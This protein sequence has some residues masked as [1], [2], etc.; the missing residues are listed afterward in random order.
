MYENRHLHEEYSLH[1]TPLV[2]HFISNILLELW[3]IGKKITVY[4]YIRDYISFKV[5]VVK[6]IMC[7]FLSPIS[8]RLD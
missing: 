8:A 7:Q 6:L 1:H 2:T 5:C 3:F 4:C